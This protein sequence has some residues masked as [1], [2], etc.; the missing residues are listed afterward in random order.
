MN[1]DNWKD[2]QKFKV[3]KPNIEA[4]YD[5]VRSVFIQGVEQVSNRF[6]IP[7]AFILLQIQIGLK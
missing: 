6:I 1:D 7:E 3:S 2:Y 4:Y 5:L